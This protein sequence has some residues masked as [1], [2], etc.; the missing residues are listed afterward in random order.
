MIT[1]L[2]DFFYYG[3]Y[4]YVGDGVPTE[5]ARVVRG[6]LVSS[7]PAPLPGPGDADVSVIEEVPGKYLVGASGVVYGL[8]SESKL[9]AAAI[10]DLELKF[11]PLGGGEGGSVSITPDPAVPGSYLIGE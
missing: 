10:A 9:P 6:D 7:K 5:V 4:Y 1:A 2:K 11:E 8:T 3:V